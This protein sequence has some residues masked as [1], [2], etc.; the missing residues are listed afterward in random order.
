[1]CYWLQISYIEHLLCHAKAE[2]NPVGN[3]S[4]IMGFEKR[5]ASNLVAPRY[6]FE[7]GLLQID[8]FLFI[9][10]LYTW[11]RNILFRVVHL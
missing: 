9:L 7:A 1:M 5:P 4:C 3:T 6:L 11:H 2:K 10:Q 8:N